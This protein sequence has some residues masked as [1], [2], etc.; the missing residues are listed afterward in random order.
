MTE[1]GEV[2]FERY[3][4]PGIAARH[5]EQLVHALFLTTFN[6]PGPAAPQAWLDLMDKMAE[7][8]ARAYRDL[9]YEE[10]RFIDYFY[11]A[12]PIAE[13]VRLNIGSRPASRTSGRRI[14]DLRAIPWV[15]AWMQS[16]HTLPGWY[17]LGA[18]LEACVQQGD[19]G[20]AL[21]R[22]MYAEWPFFTTLIDNAQMIL[23]KADMRI[24]HSYAALAKDRAMADLIFGRIAA[25]YACTVQNI[26]LVTDQKQMLDHMPTL[27]RSIDRRN[28]YIDPLSAIQ[29]ELLRRL[30][31]TPDDAD[32]DQLREAVLLSINGIAAGL[33]N[34]G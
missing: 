5:L 32:I 20:V 25:E 17:G 18:A 7:D 14:Q 30:R 22:R 1:Q 19:D 13:L 27:Q 21:L 12:T 4:L 2:I 23:S 24:A 33:K 10:P 29:V 6:P 26:L 16:R 8:S 11:E 3:G 31:E 9:V 15:F 28:P 34:T